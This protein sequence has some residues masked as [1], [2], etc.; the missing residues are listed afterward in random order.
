MDEDEYGD[1]DWNYDQAETAADEDEEGE[2]DEDPDRYKENEEITKECLEAFASTDYIM[3]PGVFKDLKRYFKAGG[4]PEQVVVLLS[5]HYTAVAQTVNLLAEWLIF[6]G[7]NP[8]EVQQMVEDHLKVLIVKHFDPKKADT[9]FSEEGGTPAWLEAMIQHRTWRALFYQLAESYP[10][11]LML[12]F[13][14]KLISDAGFQGEIGVVTTACHEIGVFSKVLQTSINK[15]LEGGEEA[16][17]KHL[18]E[19]SKMV[20]HGQHTFLYAEVMMQLLARQDGGESIIRRLCQEV[21]SVGYQ[22][23]EGV[24]Q[25]S[26][27]VS[28]ATAYPRACQALVSMISRK[29]LNPADMSV[30]YKMYSDPDPPPVELIRVPQFFSLFMEALFKPGATIN[31]DHRPKYTYLLAHATC[32]HETWRLGKRTSVTKDELKATNIAIEK[33]HA[34]C[35]SGKKGESELSSELTMVYQCIRYPVI[36]MGVVYW[37]DCVVQDPTYFQRL[38]DHTPIHL[39]LLDEVVNCHQLLHSK[40]LDVLMRQFSAPCPELDV[41]VQMELKKT[42]LDR[43]VHLLSRGFVVP[44]IKYIAKCVEKQDT[45]ISLIR[46]FVTEVLDMIA[47]PYTSDFVQLFL[48]VIENS[49]ITDSLRNEDGKDPVS[50]FIVHCKTHFIMM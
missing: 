24:T 35:S 21:Q 4:G 48:P 45:D 16:I 43:M 32:A 2:E 15:L 25:I 10:D 12:N 26:L 38:T 39:L 22:R 37:V 18:P 50:D 6:T 27:A 20:C 46:H 23:G 49:D 5:E 3:E 36:A 33:V 7:V 17:V 44:V 42:I 13:T 8:T 47:P 19:F 1:I 41:M 30:L 29:A 14:I 28:G 40:V 34:I 31:S 9:I 11:C